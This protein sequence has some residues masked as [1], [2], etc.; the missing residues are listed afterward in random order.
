MKIYLKALDNDKNYGQV[1]SVQSV[2]KINSIV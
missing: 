2:S 1:Y